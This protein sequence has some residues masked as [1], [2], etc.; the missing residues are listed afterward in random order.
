MSNTS[1]A[2]STP[3]VCYSLDEISPTYDFNTP[4]TNAMSSNTV[5]Q[6]N[7]V[8]FPG[9]QDNMSIYFNRRKGVVRI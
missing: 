5:G 8:I 4:D 3:F 6:S 9:E 2:P 7:H 1:L